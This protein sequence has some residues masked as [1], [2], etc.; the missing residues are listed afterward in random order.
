MG[1]LAHADDVRRAREELDGKLIDGLN[2]KPTGPLTEAQIRET[3]ARSKAKAKAKSPD[4][5][6]AKRTA[7]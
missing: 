6:P 3:L 1:S 7:T 4:Q 2:S 5:S